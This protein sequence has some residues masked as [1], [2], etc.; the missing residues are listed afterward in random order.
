V[1]TTHLNTSAKHP[2]PRCV[3]GGF[4]VNTVYANKIAAVKDP[5]ESSLHR[6]SKAGGEKW[7]RSSM[8]SESIVNTM[9][10]PERLRKEFLSRLVGSDVWTRSALGG[11]HLVSAA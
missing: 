10:T 2:R 9:V 5:K 1:T 3:R 11:H 4:S 7:R 8:D 6:W